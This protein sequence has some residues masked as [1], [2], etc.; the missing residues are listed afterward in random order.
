M[1]IWF[2]GLAWLC[3]DNA[4]IDRADIKQYIDLC[5]TSH[6]V[7]Q[8][9]ARLTFSGARSDSPPTAAIY[10]ILRSCLLEIMRVGLVPEVVRCFH[11]QRT[12]ESFC[13]RFGGHFS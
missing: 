4:F 6:S 1:L 9:E 12:S 3:A 5:A 8:W 7:C 11:R 13:W 2:F 10:W